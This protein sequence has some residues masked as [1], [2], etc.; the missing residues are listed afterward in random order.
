MP[1]LSV[2]VMAYNERN[3]LEAVCSEIEKTLVSLKTT[4]EIV[5]IDDGST[6]GSSELCHR[7]A[8]KIPQ[9]RTISHETNLG[10]SEVYRTGFKT[11]KGEWFTFF[12]ADGQFPASILVQFFE[13]SENADLVLGYLA[14]GRFSLTGSLLS[15]LERAMYR[16]WI[17]EMP[18]FQGVFLS[19]RR[20]LEDI[21]PKT[22][23]RGHCFILEFILLAS[24]KNY[25]IKHVKTPVRPRQSGKSKVSNL[26]TITSNISQVLKL[27]KTLR[28]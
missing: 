2:L 19:R 1:K 23:G 7:L 12:P 24:Q 8:K 5:I 4:F 20:L 16:L 21:E 14:N 28:H 3:S 11:A 10:L 26:R 6:D 27:R 18:R 22:R 17:G 15:F 13:V 9:L 25:R